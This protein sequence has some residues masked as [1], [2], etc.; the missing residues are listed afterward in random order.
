MKRYETPTLPM[1]LRYRD[2]TV[3]SDYLFDFLIFTIVNENV[4]FDKRIEYSETSE[5]KFNIEFTQE[6]TGALTDGT[7][8]EMQLNIMV[9]DDRV[10]TDI[11]RGKVER[12]LYNEV[13]I[14]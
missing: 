12:N 3:A 5:G 1:T 14:I 9:G 8:Y 4:R 13:I 10:V 7:V 2:G 6:E 11:K